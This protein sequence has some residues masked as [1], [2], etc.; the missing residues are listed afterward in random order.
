MKTPALESL[1]NKVASLQ[2]CNF[3]RKRFQH[4]CFP[5]TN[6]L[7]T[8][9]LKNASELTLGSHCLNSCFQNHADSVTLQKY[10]LLS[11]QSFNPIQDGPLWGCSR[12]GCQKGPPL[13]KVCHTYSTL[14]KLGTV[15]P[16]LKNIQKT[17]KSRDKPLEFY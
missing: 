2:N 6:L 8:A 11:N 16:Y 4:R 1:F 14:I 13:S 12:W 10:Q 7:R 9:I 3:I 5:L 17:D 15:I